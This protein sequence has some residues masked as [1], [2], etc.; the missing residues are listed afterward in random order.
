MGTDENIN[1]ALLKW[2][3]FMRGSNIP[4]NRPI[5]LENALQKSLIMAILKRPT[6][7]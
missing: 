7:V 6:D 5:L 2:F 3:T 4:I 1:D